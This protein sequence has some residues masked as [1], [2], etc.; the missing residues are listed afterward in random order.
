MGV[1]QSLNQPALRTLGATHSPAG[2]D[3][4]KGSL[5]IEI[6]NALQREGLTVREAHART[7]FAA[8]DFSRIRNA[9]LDRFSVERLLTILARLGS[10]VELSINVQHGVTA[11][12]AHPL[13]AR[14]RRQMALMCRRYGV[15]KMSIFGSILREDFDQ[16]SSDVDIS[17]EFGASGGR[18][19]AHQYF[20]LKA[21]LES[22]LSRKVDLVE[23][24]AMPS[25]RLKRIIEKTQVPIYGKAA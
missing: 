4:L 24:S 7:G 17:V 8:A 22:L 15:K 21:D 12:A 20:D 3:D 19:P 9:D 14:H 10:R 25:S 18:S 6:A 23:L 5:G 1:N 16:S 2:V 13:I 11:G